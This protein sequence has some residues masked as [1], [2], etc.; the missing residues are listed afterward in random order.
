MRLSRNINFSALVFDCREYES[1]KVY[2]S[3]TLLLQRFVSLLIHHVG[4]CSLRV[5]FDLF[6]TRVGRDS[7]PRNH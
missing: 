5:L 6:E 2:K 7:A 4:R 3:I 1:E